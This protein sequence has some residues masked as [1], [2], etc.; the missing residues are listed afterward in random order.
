M[1]DDAGHHLFEDRLHPAGNLFARTAGSTAGGTTGIM[2]TSLT[3]TDVTDSTETFSLLSLLS[4]KPLRWKITLLHLTPSALLQPS[5]KAGS[6]SGRQKR[7]LF[8]GCVH[9]DKAALCIEPAIWGLILDKNQ[10]TPYYATGNTT[11][12]KGKK[13][14]LC[15]NP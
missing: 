4:P 8:R 10:Q 5:R 13:E 6:L 11:C 1:L 2:D 7:A 9:G 12:H 14:R 3:I 15:W